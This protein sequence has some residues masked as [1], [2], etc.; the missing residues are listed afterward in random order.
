[1]IDVY[2][3][4]PGIEGRWLLEV[5]PPEEELPPDDPADSC[6]DWAQATVDYSSVYLDACPCTATQAAIDPRYF[7]IH[8]DY[9]RFVF[10]SSSMETLDSSI[11]GGMRQVN[12]SYSSNVCFVHNDD[13]KCTCHQL[14]VWHCSCS[15]I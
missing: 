1:M 6:Y 4:I 13:M 2:Y 10:A 11:Y 14:Q 15:D 9:Y 12:K 7:F 8:A 5:S 3:N